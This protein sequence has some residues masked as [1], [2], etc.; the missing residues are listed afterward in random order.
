ME[1]AQGSVVSVGENMTGA[2]VMDVPSAKNA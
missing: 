1:A 2:L